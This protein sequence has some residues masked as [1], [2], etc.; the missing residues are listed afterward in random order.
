VVATPAAICWGAT[1]QLQAMGSGG[2]GNYSYKWYFPNGDSTTIPNPTVQPTVTSTYTCVVSDGYNKSTSTITV[3]VNQLPIANAGDN[4]TI[5]YGTYVFLNGS[6]TGGSG[7]YSYAWTP[8]DKLLI[9]GV[10]SPQTTNLTGT[11]PY[12][13][14]VTDNGTSCISNPA[15]VVV[16]VD[17]VRLSVSPYASH[18]WICIGD[19]SQL[20]PLAIGGNTGNYTYSWGSNPP[21][22]S[23][24]VSDPYVWPTVNTT[25]YVNVKD[26]AIG[27][28]TGT[29]NVNIYASPYI[30]M[31]PRDSTVCTYATVTLDAGNPGSTYLWSDG[32]NTQTIEL[33]STGIGYEVQQYEVQVTNEHGCIS[34]D[35]ISVHFSFS[36]CTGISETQKKGSIRIY[37]NPNS[38]VFTIE[39][40]GFEKEISATILNMVGQKIVSFILPQQQPGKFVKTSDLRNLPKGIYLV[41]FESDNYLRT[42]KLVI[43]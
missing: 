20:H 17:G 33:V 31:G 35:S 19:T 10:Q 39:A 3:V 41:R 36:A 21:G 43:R 4:D 5:K 23:S 29:I 6:V 40:A 9:A 24:T 13:L 32:E 7:S 15:N 37:P 12:S 18:D 1:S 28:T 2:T 34:T 14:I 30:H 8:A 38:G 16:F 42:E 25:Y 11:V 27:D 22:F 26:G